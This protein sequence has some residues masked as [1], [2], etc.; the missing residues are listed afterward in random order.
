MWNKNLNLILG[1]QRCM[2]DK[3]GL[4]YNPQKQQKMYKKIFISFQNSSSPNLTCTYCNKKGHIA[5]I[6]YIRK[7]GNN[8]MIWVPKG[9]LTM[10][11]LQGPKKVWVPKLRN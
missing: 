4:G 5:S 3:A 1:Q 11:N 6:C 7:N 10:T 2:F 9:S 8:K